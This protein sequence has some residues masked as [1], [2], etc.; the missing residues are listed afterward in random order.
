M[1][2]QEIKERRNKRNEELRLKF[3]VSNNNYIMPKVERKTKILSQLR[4][5]LGKS[6]EGFKKIFE[7]YNHLLSQKNP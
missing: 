5:K 3:I 2:P 1:N 6:K 4:I 7:L